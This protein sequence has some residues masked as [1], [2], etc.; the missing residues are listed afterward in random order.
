M[1][2]FL[3]LV[4]QFT[5]YIHTVILK[6]KSEAKKSIEDYRKFF[7]KQ[8]GFQLKKLILDGGGAFCNK[9]LNETLKAEGIQH[10]VAPPYTPQNNGL[11]ER[12]N[13]TMIDMT[14]CQMMQANMAPE[15][16]GEAVKMATATTNCLLSLS[17]SKKTP[18]E[19]MFK[20]KPNLNFFYPFGCC[21]WIVKPKQ[22]R[23]TKFNSISWEG[24]LL[25]YKNDYLSYK[26]LQL[27]DKSIS[28]E[29]HVYFDKTTFP[30]CPALN[31]SHVPL[32]VNKLPMFNGDNSLPSVDYDPNDTTKAQE[33][34]QEME[35]IVS[36]LQSQS[37][38][39]EQE[40][41][42]MT[43]EGGTYSGGKFAWTL[44]PPANEV[45][46]NV[47]KRNILTKK[48]RQ[49]AFLVAVALEPKNHRQ[50]MNSSEAMK[51]KEAEL[52]EINNMNKHHVWDIRPREQS[53]NPI[54]LTWAYRKK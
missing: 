51:W 6:A 39:V 54:T 40:E 43:P 14:R 16:W 11:A 33:E 30:D 36:R 3:T 2:Y 42:V 25:G 7:E 47:D 34:E 13:Q 50:A 10:N 5:G 17:K 15:W 52:K 32:E 20:M 49:Q 41:S 24:I 21:V 29:K 37:P 23:G 4:D 9:E 45:H 8:S 44:Q 48:R 46:G 31:K 26:V 35:D 1:Q 53:D 18:I 38:G 19:L 28:P 22:K 12:A 27:D